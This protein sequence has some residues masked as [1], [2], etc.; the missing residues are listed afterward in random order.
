MSEEAASQVE[1]ITTLSLHDRWR[2]HNYW[3]R[4][5]YEYVNTENFKG[6][7]RLCQ[8]YDEACK[9]KNK[10]ALEA[11]DVIGMTTTGAAK[12]QHIL[13]FVKPK[14]VIVEEA[15]EVLESH[16]VSAL[17]AGTQHLILIGDHKQLKPK[18]NEYELAKRFKLDVSLFERLV[19]RKFP[20][21]TLQIQHRMRP[22]IAQLVCPHIYKTLINHESV[23]QYRDVHVKGVSKDLFFIQHDFPESEDTNL[24]SHSN[25]HE[26]KFI[27]AL[28][29]YLLQQGY[30]PDQITVLTPYVGQLLRIR[31]KMPRITFAGVRVSAVDNF[32]GEEND[33]ILLSLVRSNAEGKLGFL[34]EENR[35]CV[36]LSRAKIGFYCIGNFKML[37]QK[38]YLWET[39]TSDMEHKGYLGDALP[40]HCYNH[41]KTTFEAK[42]PADFGKNAP[43]GGCLVP[44]EYRLH[45]GHVCTQLCHPKDPEHKEFM[46]MKDCVR[47]CKEGHEHPQHL[48]HEECPR[49]KVR[50]E[51][52]M[53]I[54]C[55]KQWMFCYED[56]NEFKCKAPC[57]RFCDA[58]TH[59]CKKLCYQQCDRGCQVQVTREIPKCG[60]MQRM[61]CWQDP[62]QF[63]CKVQVVRQIPRCGHMQAMECWQ[64]PNE[65]D[66]KFQCIRSC[67][68]GH[69]YTAPCHEDPNE[70]D[71]K[72]QCKRSCKNGHLYTAPC[73]EDPS[74]FKCSVHVTKKIPKCGHIQEIPCWYETDENLLQ[75]TK[76]CEKK[77]ECG[78]PCP[79]KCGEPCPIISC[80]V[81]VEVS[82]HCGHTMVMPCYRRKLQTILHYTLTAA[83]DVKKLFPVVTLVTKCVASLVPQNVKKL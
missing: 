82:L 63:R 56:L 60:H 16:I 23:L 51:R 74:E 47:K 13:H 69:L 1:D 43:T 48:C 3:A 78:H 41:P 49:C 45:C 12:Y 27:V 65:F 50:V 7:T 4:R 36:S 37:C 31:N 80:K 15:A 10:C 14:I 38:S 53:N 77:Q 26:A 17:S 68:N 46:C 21:T 79:R 32:Q 81:K 59:Q 52:V 5:H 35:V 39:I 9:E 70:F 2:L 8:E 19:T 75:C 67:K 42:L 44:C 57:E 24:M 54:C 28:C 22:E 76:P 25:E 30:K 64:D 29:S 18:P 83:T 71:C 34:R 11:A 20:H 73:H 40:L 72:V 61:F 55:H 33:I 66:C 62:L 58:K 6:Y